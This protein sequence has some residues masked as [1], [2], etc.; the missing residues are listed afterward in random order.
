ML[1]SLSL[2]LKHNKYHT[3]GFLEPPLYGIPQWN[4]TSKILTK[5]LEN[6]QLPDRVW[7]TPLQRICIS[8]SNTVPF[9]PSS[10]RFLGHCWLRLK[11]QTSISG[12]LLNFIEHVNPDIP[13][14]KN[15]EREHTQESTSSIRN[16]FA[17]VNN[18]PTALPDESQGDHFPA[19]P[20]TRDRSSIS[21]A[22]KTRPHSTGNPLELQSSNVTRLFAT[23]VK[24]N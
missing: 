24:F 17:S 5:S 1:F 21:V 16:R 2:P 15:E 13:S 6:I 14:W 23:Q 10:S 11:Q 9:S 3:K 8:E 18:P 19:W 4:A 20:L 22:L 12:L 7:H